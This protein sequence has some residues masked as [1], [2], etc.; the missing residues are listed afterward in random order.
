[1]T[2][3]Q[4]GPTSIHQTSE[5]GPAT[6]RQQSLLRGETNCGVGRKPKKKKKNKKNYKSGELPPGRYI[7]EIL[8]L[9][10]AAI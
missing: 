7:R 3:F 8:S 5:L 10:S 1:M 9:R 6:G 4:K 2:R